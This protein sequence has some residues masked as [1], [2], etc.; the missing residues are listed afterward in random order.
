MR[1]EPFPPEK[2]WFTEDSLYLI[3]SSSISFYIPLAVMLYTYFRIFKAA[4]RQIR[5]IQMGAKFYYDKELELKLKMRI[6][7]GS[8][9]G[10]P[11]IP[12]SPSKANQLCSS[13]IELRPLSWNREF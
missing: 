3:L 1:I 7:V 13:G 12:R 2:C 11:Q 6:H 9:P 8:G 4:V 5:G 10:T